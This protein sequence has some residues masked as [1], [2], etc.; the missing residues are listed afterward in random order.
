MEDIMV[1]DKAKYHYGGDYP[2][3]LPQEQAF[4][5]TGMFL[6]WLIDNDLCSE[7]FKNEAKDQIEAFKKREITGADVYAHW[8]GCLLSDMLSDEGNNFAEAYYEGKYLDDYDE[9]LTPDLPSIYQAENTWDNYEKIKNR[10][11]MRYKEFTQ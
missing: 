8:D 10:I 1:Y 5:H 11:D 7:E 6:G 2:E 4:V 9:L 3:G